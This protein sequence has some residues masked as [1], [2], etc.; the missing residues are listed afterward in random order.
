MLCT[1]RAALL[2]PAPPQRRVRPLAAAQIRRPEGGN[3]QRRLRLRYPEF[4]SCPFTHTN[5][6]TGAVTPGCSRP[7]HQRATGELCSTLAARTDTWHQFWPSA[8]TL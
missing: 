2:R 7:C 3:T 1:T 4:R 6:V 8:V 5:P